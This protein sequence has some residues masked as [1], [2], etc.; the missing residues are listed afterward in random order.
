MLNLKNLFWQA[1]RSLSDFC[2]LKIFTEIYIL[3]K[4]YVS[5]LIFKTCEAPS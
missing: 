3:L 1:N 2:D 5:S 4:V